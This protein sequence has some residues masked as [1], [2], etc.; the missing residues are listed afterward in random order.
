MS[1]QPVFFSTIYKTVDFFSFS[2]MLLLLDFL[3]AAAFDL[4]YK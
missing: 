2:L 1:F 3:M 4:F